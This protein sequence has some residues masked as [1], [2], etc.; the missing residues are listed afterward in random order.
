[1]IT[2][3]SVVLNRIKSHLGYKKEKE[4]AEFLGISAQRLSLWRRRNSYDPYLLYEKLH[5]KYE[6]FDAKFLLTGEGSMIL[7]QG[8]DD[9][10]KMCRKKDQTIRELEKIIETKNELIKSKDDLIE[11][12]NETIRALN[13][14]IAI[15][16][17]A[18]AS[19][20]DGTLY[21][22]I[23]KA[24]SKDKNSRNTKRL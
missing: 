20:R 19:Y 2:D 10:C 6:E 3:K 17:K 11:A 23:M 14:K 12:K 24:K 1:M 13:D 21:H 7:G 18:I 5:E 16:D 8:K 9:L 22:M 4:F 15:L